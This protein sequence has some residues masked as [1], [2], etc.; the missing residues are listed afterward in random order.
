M[1]SANEFYTK[2]A[3]TAYYKRSFLRVLAG[4]GCT[5]IEAELALGI[6]S[7]IIDSA[8]FTGSLGVIQDMDHAFRLL[9]QA[10][11]SCNQTNVIK[12]LEYMGVSPE[13]AGQIY[14]KMICL[15]KEQ[16][17][18]VLKCLF[19]RRVVGGIESAEHGN[20]RGNAAPPPTL[21]ELMSDPTLFLNYL[22]SIRP[23]VH[24]VAGPPALSLST[25]AIT[26]FQEFM[27]SFDGSA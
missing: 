21:M 4:V 13:N 22:K 14:Q 27:D 16:M 18:F 9:N 6:V 19:M 26:S 10:Y 7:S 12:L 15:T 8:L 2:L 24:G 20:P 3:F 17:K 5:Y 1:I 23:G 11:Q 25:R